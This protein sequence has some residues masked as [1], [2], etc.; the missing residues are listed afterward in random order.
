MW[1]KIAQILSTKMKEQE[2][3]K[4]NSVKFVKLGNVVERGD[5]IQTYPQEWVLDKKI[6]VL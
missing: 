1:I 5:N 2:K 4:K 6:S 3:D